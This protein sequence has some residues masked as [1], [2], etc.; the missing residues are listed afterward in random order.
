M[1]RFYVKKND[2]WNIFSSIIDDYLYQDFMSFDE[3]QAV[4]VGEA[5]AA[6]IRD[7]GTLLTSS[8]KL[9][10][11]S[12]EEAEEIIR[13]QEPADTHEEGDECGR[14]FGASFND[15]DECRGLAPDPDCQWT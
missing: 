9:N 15:C 10:T 7:L 2:K 13:A 12:Y 6:K 14:C 5:V 8:P 3:L 1:A 4:I 11:L